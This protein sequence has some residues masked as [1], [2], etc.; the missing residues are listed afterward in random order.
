MT[1]KIIDFSLVSSKIDDRWVRI[2]KEKPKLAFDQNS[3]NK[4]ALSTHQEHN[5][6]R[7]KKPERAKVARSSIF[8]SRG[9][10]PCQHDKLASLLR[11]DS[12]VT[13]SDITEKSN[14][15]YQFK[16]VS[17]EE[18]PSQISKAKYSFEQSFEH[19]SKADQDKI[20]LQMIKASYQSRNKALTIKAPHYRLKMRIN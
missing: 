5:Y 11:V 12:Q 10:S 16:T 19:M 13:N 6:I 18:H 1:R 9:S 3:P 7:F 17:F 20:N 8:N 15:N 4:S 2:K 14:D